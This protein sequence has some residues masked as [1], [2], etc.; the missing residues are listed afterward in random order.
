MGFVACFLLYSHTRRFPQL[1]FPSWRWALIVPVIVA[2]W[3]AH[4]R[5][6]ASSL[7][8]LPCV[9]RRLVSASRPSARLV[10]P[11]GRPVSPSCSLPLSASSGD[12][13]SRSHGVF[14]L[15]YPYAPFL[16]AQFP[17]CFPSRSL[18]GSVRANRLT[19]HRGHRPF[20][21]GHRRNANGATP[22]EHEAQ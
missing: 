19:E 2:A 6:P 13:V 9:S 22:G 15:R 7:L 12:G 4:P 11:V 21:M 5:S 18:K 3:C 8:S 17:I 10:S 14:A 16:S 1:R 20:H